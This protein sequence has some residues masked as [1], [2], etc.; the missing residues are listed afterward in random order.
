M[1]YECPN[2]DNY[3]KDIHDNDNL[4]NDNH[5]EQTKI[6]RVTKTKTTKPTNIFLL[7]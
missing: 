3:C 4:D 5:N 2:K 7:V 6:V 1:L